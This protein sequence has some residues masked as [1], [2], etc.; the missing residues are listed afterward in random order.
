MIF[1]EMINTL[2]N[3]KFGRYKSEPHKVNIKAAGNFF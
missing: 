3:T 1:L 2:D